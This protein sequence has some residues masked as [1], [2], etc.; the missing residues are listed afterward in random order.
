MKPNILSASTLTRYRFG[1]SEVERTHQLI[2]EDLSQFR[3]NSIVDNVAGT[4]EAPSEIGSVGDNSNPD[5]ML[6]TSMGFLPYLL[7]TPSTTAT[8]DSTEAQLFFSPTEKDVTTSLA[9]LSTQMSTYLSPEDTQKVLDAVMV[10][11]GYT[12]LHNVNDKEEKMEGGGE[13]MFDEARVVVGCMEFLHILALSE[14]NADTLI[15]ASFH[16][17]SAVSTLRSKKLCVNNARA[18]QL[19]T[20]ELSYLQ[21]LAGTGIETFGLEPA[22]IAVIAA[23]LKRVET[24]AA[25]LGNQPETTATTISRY[26]SLRSLLLTTTTDW[27]ALAIRVA[28]CLY[29]LRLLERMH[30]AYPTVSRRKEYVHAAREAMHLFS[31]L[32]KRLGMHV[33]KTEIDET[34]FRAVYPKQSRMVKKLLNEGDSGKGLDSVLEEVQRGVK[35]LLHEDDVFMEE[36][37]QVTVKAR[38]KE[39]FSLWKKM[40]K[41]NTNSIDD[42]SDLIAMRIIIKARPKK[43]GEAK[44]ITRARERALCYYVQEM[45]LRKYPS[46]DSSRTKDYVKIPKGNGYQSLHSTSSVRWHGRS[47]PFEVQVRTG[48]MHRVAEYGIAAHWVY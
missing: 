44:H 5:T 6:L 36:I 43:P 46:F 38:K 3:F 26:H 31:P 14:M 34:A 7:Q 22:K 27:R 24:I 16:F 13:F 10:A 40:I 48:E 39:P 37:E 4:V 25:S 2:G 33:I 19:E 41:L 30:S 29:R 45:V 28:G 9:T 18:V 1:D 8:S 32:A 17:A 23:R 47:W 42:V 11:S 15:G 35:S 21:H 20:L 12:G